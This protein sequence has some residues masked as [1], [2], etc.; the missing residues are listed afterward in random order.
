[1][2]VRR[3]EACVLVA[4]LKSMVPFAEG[5]SPV[6]LLDKL[7][8]IL[9]AI[10][11][12][13]ADHGGIVA[14]TGPGCAHVLWDQEDT[15]ECMACAMRL[16]S[17][18]NS[19]S[20][21]IAIGV[22]RGPCEVSEDRTDARLITNETVRRAEALSECS[23]RMDAQVLVDESLGTEIWSY[24]RQIAKCSSLGF[25]GV[26]YVVAPPDSPPETTRD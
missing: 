15:S 14:R 6:Q 12:L 5:N 8:E 22:S 9:A 17:E 13:A 18:L 21:P 16:S 20:S 24:T 11:K 26:A 23:R 7:T 10:K 2:E 1:M 19:G 4:Q 25:P 3:F